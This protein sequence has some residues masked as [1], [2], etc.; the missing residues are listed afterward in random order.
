ML[1][2]QNLI[3]KNKLDAILVYGDEY[4]SRY[5]KYTTG[6]E[7]VS[8]GFILIQPKSIK[9]ATFSY[10]LDDLKKKTNLEVVSIEDDITVKRDLSILLKDFNKVGI[11]GNLPYRFLDQKK[12]YLDIT[13]DFEKLI[14]VKTSKDIK[15]IYSSAKLLSKIL[16]EVGK[17]L[18]GG[19]TSE[20]EIEKLIKKLIIENSAK[21]AF[22]VSICSDELLLKSTVGTARNRNIEKY[23]CIDVGL[24]KNGFYSDMTRMFFLK[25][26]SVFDS[27]SKLS[28]IK[29]KISKN[30]RNFTSMKSLKKLLNSELEKNGFSGLS[31]EYVGHGIGFGLH[32]FPVFFQKESKDFKFK[33]GNVFTLEPEVRLNNGVNIRIEDM[34]RINSKGGIIQLT[35]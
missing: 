6:I 5:I 9:I 15:G 12:V 14:S 22:P 30:S 24:V 8:L 20:I 4:D 34:Y 35:Y 13:E 3:K 19:L 17:R 28:F 33:C 1:K 29:K 21:E 2:L 23:V 11:V 18:V 27:Y 25:K 31:D 16:D 32:E 7:I 10:L 26:D